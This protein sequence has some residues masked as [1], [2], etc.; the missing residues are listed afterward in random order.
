MLKIRLQRKGRK[1]SPFYHIVTADA[2]SPRD[3]KFIDKIGTYNPLT[4][5]ASIELDRDAAYEWLMKGAQPTDTVRAI[6]KFKGVYYKKHLQR[7]VTKGAM[8]QE[9]ADAL[10]AKWVDAKD[11]KIE[12]RKAAVANAAEERRKKIF[13]VAP[14]KKEAKKEAPAAEETTTEDNAEA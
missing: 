9:A 13:G 1:K 3:G 6:L 10:L 14:A 4:V 2:R 5:P 12:T 11:T 8:T 7:G